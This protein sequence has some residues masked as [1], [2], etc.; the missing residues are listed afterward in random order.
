MTLLVGGAVLGGLYIY[1]ARR[2]RIH[3]I[4]TYLEPIADRLSRGRPGGKHRGG[5][6]KPPTPPLG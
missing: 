2:L 3:E 4:D 1:L 6:P 5:I